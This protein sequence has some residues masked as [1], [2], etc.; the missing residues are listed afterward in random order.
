MTNDV[1]IPSVISYSITHSEIKER[2]FGADLS[3]DAITMVNTKLELDVQETRLDELNLIIQVLDGMKDL[4]FDHIKASKGMPEY[5]WKNPE[6]IVTD[7]L[8]K[9]FEPFLDATEYMAA[10]RALAP[11]DVVITV[12]VVSHLMLSTATDL[13]SIELVIPGE[14]L[15]FEGSAKCRLQ[16]NKFPPP[17]QVR[18]GF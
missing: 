14:K 3:P 7:Y 11:V 2:Q 4:G 12:P 9:A 18:H 1:K 17:Q 8:K 13:T 6:A 15:D 5:T 16:P 10:I